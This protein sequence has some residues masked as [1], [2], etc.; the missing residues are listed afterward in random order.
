[1]T[2][3]LYLIM[4]RSVGESSSLFYLPEGVHSSKHMQW[5]PRRQAVM[6]RYQGP[7]EFLVLLDLLVASW[8]TQD[9]HRLDLECDSTGCWE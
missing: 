9:A 8:Y 5:K 4:C 6:A 7:R 3:S 2:E 1:M